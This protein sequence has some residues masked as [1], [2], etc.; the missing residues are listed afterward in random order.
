MGSKRVTGGKSGLTGRFSYFVAFLN[1]DKLHRLKMRMPHKFN[2]FEKVQHDQYA[3]SH[4]E[5]A[6][7]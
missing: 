2:P 7:S 5:D 6:L 4:N 3:D 1:G